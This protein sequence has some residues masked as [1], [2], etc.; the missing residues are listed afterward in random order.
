MKILNNTAISI[1]PFIGS[2]NYLQ[3]QEFYQLL[4]FQVMNVGPKLSFVKVNDTVGFYLQDA[5]V[6]KWVDNTM[7]FIEVEDVEAWH[8]KIKALDLE[9]KYKLVR[10]SE[11]QIEHWG[12]EFFLH[13]PEGILWHIGKFN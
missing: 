8:Q 10:C 11:I 9:S 4:G 1:R 12:K 3:S 5:Y 2:K 13:D 6:K 7:L